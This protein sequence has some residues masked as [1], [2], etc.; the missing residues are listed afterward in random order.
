M[1]LSNMIELLI[2]YKNTLGDVEVYEA[3]KEYG[4]DTF[5]EESFRKFLHL[6]TINTCS[7]EGV[8]KQDYLVMGKH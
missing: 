1:K 6:E 7:K 4:W 8:S 5:T 3:S 2:Q